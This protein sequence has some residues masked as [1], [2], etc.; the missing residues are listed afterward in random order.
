MFFVLSKVLN[1]FLAP[2]NIMVGLGLAGIALLA[3]GFARA[4]RW[5][6][7]ASTL[8]IV[9]VGVLPIGS[10]LTRPLEARFPRWDPTRGPPTGIIVLGGGVIKPEKSAD[11]GEIVLGCTAERI[12]SAV[13]L[14]RRYPDARVV[15][16]GGS[17]DLIS[18][19]LAE[20]D[21]VVGLFQKLG[22]PRGRVVVERESRDTSEN[23]TFSKQLVMPK[24][25]ERW[26]LVTSAIHMPRAIGVFRKAGFAVEAYPVNYE[27]N[28]T[29]DLWAVSSA[30]MGGIWQT[31]LAAHE[32]MGLLAYWITGR[33]SAP[34]P[35][36]MFERNS[37]AA[38]QRRRP[39]DLS[40]VPEIAINAKCFS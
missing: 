38:P 34:F 30:L 14:A 16:A 35:G 37:S 12:F 9:T 19:G 22:V 20:A 24:E 26:L 27:T 18:G 21:F 1:F 40:A 36:P 25:G 13:E 39:D 15:F 29:Q 7:V 2:S 3:M 5:M 6:L 11:Q 8:L 23:A 33:I 17:G 4:G 28:S 31:D 10:V 32:W